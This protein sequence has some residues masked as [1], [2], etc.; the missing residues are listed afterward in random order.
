MNKDIEIGDWVASEVSALQGKV[1]AVTTLSLYGPYRRKPA[2]EVDVGD[3]YVHFFL[4]ES[5]RLLRKRDIEEREK[6]DEIAV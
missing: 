4:K 2:F 3:G 6:Q 5:T 1:V